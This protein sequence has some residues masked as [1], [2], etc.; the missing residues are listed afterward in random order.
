MRRVWWTLRCDNNHAWDVEA[1]DAP[2]P[3]TEALRCPIDGEQAGTVRKEEPA[4]RVRI[5]LASGA[6]IT[7]PVRG[8]VTHD[9]DWFVEVSSFDGSRSMRTSEAW[10]WAVAVNKESCALSEPHVGRGQ[11]A[12][13]PDHALS[14]RSLVAVG[15][16]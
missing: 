9:G 3:P 7:D 15:P 14:S 12:V 5:T 13:D 6:R 8:T 4:D 11:D 10:P 1:H 2:E 16:C